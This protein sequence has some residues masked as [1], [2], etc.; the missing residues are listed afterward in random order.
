MFAFLV[1]ASLRNRILVLAAVAVLMAYG[2]VIV[3]GLRI[4]VLPDLNKGLVT[5]LTEAPGLAP[6]EVEVLVSYPIESAMNGASGATRVRSVSSTGLSVVYV[7]FDW[8][9]DLYRNRQIVAERLAPVQ[10]SLPAGVQPLM[11]PLSSYMGEIMLV[12]LSS[13]SV[14]PMALREI[15]DWVVA[16]RLKAVPGVSR[17][18]PIGG[19]VKQYRITPDILQMARLEVSVDDIERVL[20]RFGSNTA[21]GFVE[22]QSQEFLIRNLTRTQSLEDLRNLVVDHRAGQPVLLRQ[23]ASVSFE[24]KQRRG[25]AG[26]MGAD[27]VVVSVQKQPDVD[28]VA[29][30]AE[31]E[32]VLAGLQRT[33]PEGVRADEILFRQADFIEAS[34]SNVKQAL[35]EAVAVVAVILF[36]FL[37][38]ARTTL[39]SLTA[40]P[41]SVLMT[42]VVFR[43]LGLTINT[44]TLGGLA[45]AIG[46][47][48]DDAVVDVE[49]IFRRLRENR[50]LASPRASLAVIMD[51]S[52][53]VRSGIVY[54]T[55]IIVLV[56]V[57]LFAIPGIEG[58]LFAPLG[59][60]YIVS[61]LASLITSITL[62]PVLCSYLLPRMKALGHHESGA[63]RH[64]KRLNT[65]AVCWVLD[66]PRA[67]MAGVGVAVITALAMVPTLP[68]AFLPSFNEGTLVMTMTL[69]PGI[70]LRESARI[71]KA[72][73]H[74]LMEIPEVTRVGRRTGRSEADEHALGVHVSEIEVGL[75]WS[76]RRIEAVLKDARARLSGLPAT[77]NIGQPISHR[78]I[79]HILTGAAA[80]VV[81]KIY[82]QDL[83]TLRNVARD[84]E[85]WMRTVPGLTDVAIEKQVP[86]PQ[87]QI[88]VDPERALLYGVQPADLA[89]RLAHLTNGSVVSEVID[90]IRRFEVNVML[91]D[92]ARSAQGL[93]ALLIDTPSGYV[94]VSLVAR[95][96][97]GTGPNE[98]LRENGQRRILVTANGDGSNGNLIAREIHE[99]LEQIRIPTGYYIAF[100]GIYAE[101]TR[102]TLRLGLM[103]LVS[104]SL[105]FAILY[106]RYR[107]VVLACIIMAN[108]PLA[109]IGSVIALKITGLPLS[110]ASII[111]F[112]TLTGISTRNGILKVSHYINLVLH[113]GETFGRALILRGSNERLVPVLM[114]A[115]SAGVALVPLILGAGEAGKEILHPVAVVVFGGLVSATA[116]DA[117]LTPLLFNRFGLKPLERLMAAQ[118]EG[119]P[120]EAY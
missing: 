105:I 80:E 116:L 15:A 10:A 64:L 2:G 54:S 79:D 16:P 85:G 75:D 98:V 43:W 71:A 97:E 68:R 99:M 27:A 8:D 12:A 94:P 11:A 9:T 102:S 38:N 40:I 25:D 41:V 92:H 28:T 65:R 107:S 19:L 32:A 14:D 93:G 109:L 113:E 42:F 96:I 39:I 13:D 53:E 36:L 84:V 22:Q 78:L 20:S 110:I 112:I 6:E 23:V 119:R 118:A 76:G 83:D 87:I 48:V 46:E 90:G 67:T 51:A 70:A 74:I 21:G 44:M 50:R 60:A 77:F 82:G 26:Y 17:V 1:G 29:L 52:Q 114:T 91:P 7:E 47:L 45:I 35:F 100:E 63:V 55:M 62:T 58:K 31:V 72:A 4:D 106:T 111:G 86:I 115:T 24:P 37:L 69:D 95:V 103:A 49:N 56:F 34:V 89:R 81:M 3:N 88:Q 108:V 117:L 59:I 5:I 57:P 66:R 18:V 73:E 120:A 30:T 104:L 33:M 61:I 101:Q